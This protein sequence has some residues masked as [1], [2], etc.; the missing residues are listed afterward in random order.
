MLPSNND[1]TFFLEVSQTLNLSRAS[2]RLGITQPALSQSIKRL[3]YA[4]GQDVLIRSKTGVKLTKAG[5]KL[6]IHARNLLSLWE[7]IKGDVAKDQSEIRGRYTLGCH[8]SVGLYTMD[9]FVPK[10]LQEFQNLEFRFHH[11]L[12]RK[13]TEDVISFKLDFG[14]VVNPV[15]HPDLVIREIYKDEVVLWTYHKKSP[16]TDYQNGTAVLICD[17][18]LSQSQELMNKISKKGIKFDRTCFTG[19]LEIVTSMVG[20]GSGIGIIPTRV[21]K[22]MGMKK[23]KVVENGP[24]FHDRICLVYRADTQNSIASRSL[25]KSIEKILKLDS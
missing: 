14:I 3:E 9:R 6:A 25:A 7:D 13:I 16:L 8:P 23:V 22:N 1:L 11:D 19:N 5:E 4:F 24:K 17:P 21:V 12:S 15:P 18:D 10:L 20:A 2:E